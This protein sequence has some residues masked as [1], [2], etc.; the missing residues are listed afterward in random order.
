MKLPLIDVLQLEYMYFSN[1]I[2]TVTH[3]YVVLVFIY[4]N[5]NIIVEH[6]KSFPLHI[7][8]CVILLIWIL[9]KISLK[10][11]TSL[12]QQSSLVK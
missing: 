7:I 8:Q 10:Q 1:R 11:V 4:C 6:L 2:F 5:A 12:L 9:Y 3:A